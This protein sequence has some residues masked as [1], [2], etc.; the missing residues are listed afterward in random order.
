[1]APKRAKAAP[2]STKQRAIAGKLEALVAQVEGHAG[3]GLPLRTV[4]GI[5]GSG[6]F[7]DGVDYGEAR[8]VIVRGDL[9]D[10]EAHTRARDRYLTFLEAV[11][12]GFDENSRRLRE[13][14]DARLS[15]ADGSHLAAPW[16][17][18]WAWP[19]PKAEPGK[20]VGDAAEWVVREVAASR[21]HTRRR[22]TDSDPVAGGFRSAHFMEGLTATR[23]A[24]AWGVTLGVDAICEVVQAWVVVGLCI[25]KEAE[26]FLLARC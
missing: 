8:V 23:L 10:E 5:F 24:E 19:A 17:K 25:L 1:M 21:L 16:W 22:E 6:A 14:L 26:G 4:A 3:L 9:R 20:L 11:C 2:L 12:Q 15:H 13:Q 18:T 7:F